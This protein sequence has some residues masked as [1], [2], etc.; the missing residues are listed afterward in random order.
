MNEKI[1]IL[2][3]SIGRRVA[4]VECFRDAFTELGIK[5][6]IVGADLTDT[7]PAYHVT[8]KSYKVCPIVNPDYIPQILDICVKENITFV[9]SVLDTDLLKLATAREEFAN[10]GS[11]MI[12][13]PP[14]VISICRDKYKTNAFLAS[15]DLLTPGLHSVDAPATDLKF[16]LFI[17]PSDG[18]SSKNTFKI[19]AI[20]EYLFFR[21]YVPNPILL[22]YIEGQEYTSD[23]YIDFYG[24]VRCIVP[25]KRLEVRAGEVSKSQIELNPSVIQP[26]RKLAQVLAA[27][28]AI[29]VLNIQCLLTSNGTVYF[30]EINPRFGGG[31]PLSIKAGYNFPKWL[32]Q[33]TFGQEIDTELEDD[34]D[35]LTMLRYDDAVFVRDV[36]RVD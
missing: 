11:R 9:F 27:R 4:L 34:G 22:D 16:P 20:E 33:E 13:S 18:S 31:C 30:I 26:T 25:R 35:G 21:N 6:A 32:I 5:G 29:G 12:I 23:I 14:D 15:L 10:V 28:R 7:A 17:K 3:T 8:D 1:N 19:S 36:E 2:I 24:R